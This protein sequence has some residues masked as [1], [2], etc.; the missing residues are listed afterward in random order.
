MKKFLLLIIS[1]FAFSS[2]A[3]AQ[4]K[5]VTDYFLAMPD[6]EN[7]PYYRNEQTTTKEELVKFRKSMI[8]IEDIKNGYLKLKGDWNGYGEI[9]LFKKTDGSYLIANSRVNCDEGCE[10]FLELYSYKN[11]NWKDVGFDLLPKYGDIVM[12]Y[13]KKRP[14]GTPA[15]NV[16]GDDTI[17]LEFVYHL[18]RVGRSIKISCNSCLP[19]QK[20]PEKEFYFAEFEWNG[21]K[22]IKK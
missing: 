8:E 10:G 14:K 4:P 17:G 18:P 6:S 19:A 5:T 20:T 15:A 13:N 11:G 12:E 1:I 9:V 21:A 3:F 2:F 16:S 22:F 7:F